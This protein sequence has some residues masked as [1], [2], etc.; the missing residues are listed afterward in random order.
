MRHASVGVALGLML[1]GCAGTPVTEAIRI[2]SNP[3]G[4][5][6]TMERDGV[7]LGHVASTPGTIEFV[8]GP[9]TLRVTCSKSGYVTAQV[10]K[11]PAYSRQDLPPIGLVPLA[12]A[13]FAPP[14]P[15]SDWQYP[16]TITVDLAGIGQAPQPLPLSGLRLQ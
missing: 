4:A 7:R 11:T 6:C 2:T 9:G 5:A 15:K 3:P 1:G 13:A 16:A 10:E 14:A 8:P 12:V